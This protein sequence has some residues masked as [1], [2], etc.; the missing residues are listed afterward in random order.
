MPDNKSPIQLKEA[1]RWSQGLPHQNQAWDWLQRQVPLSVLERF[2]ALYRNEERLSNLEPQFA[3]P[4]QAIEIIKAFEGYSSTPYRCSQGIPTVG[5]GTT[6]YPDG[7]RVQLSDPAITRQQGQDYLE[8]HITKNVLPLLVK[9][10]PF[11]MAMNSNQQS[12]LISFAYNVGAAFMQASDGFET[13]QRV[14]KT[15]DWGA[16]P[17]ALRLYRNPGT[18]SEKGLL[19]RRVAEGLLW[20]GEGEFAR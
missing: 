9:T 1:A 13:I 14:L 11:Y 20:I 6:V 8:H 17:E 7:R 15:K 4:E 16:V 2:A 10:V 18:P 19:R 3:L 12:A 5:F